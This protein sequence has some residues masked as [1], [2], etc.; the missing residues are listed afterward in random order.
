MKSKNKLKKGYFNS[1]YVGNWADMYFRNISDILLR[2]II[3]IKWITPNGITIFSS[4]IFI[5]GC[6]L[7]FIN[8]PYHLYYATFLIFVGYIGDLLDGDLAKKRNMK[9]FYGGYLDAIADVI[10]VYFITIS[11]SIFVYLT[12]NKVIFIFLGFTICASFLSRYYIKQ[13]VSKFVL[14]NQME[15]NPQFIYERF[16]IEKEWKQKIERKYKILS[17]SFVGR[18]KI[19]WLKNKKIFLVDEAEI[20]V[21][22]CIACI[23]NQLVIWI[24]ILAFSQLLIV[25]FRLFQRG[26]Q[27]KNEDYNLVQKT[28]LEI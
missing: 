1:V 21:F 2:L 4:F 15:K 22:T 27:L 18:L 28:Y 26:Y 20:A 25:V 9:S 14:I 7:L 17:K 11:L 10:K 12:T 19:L 8:I 13:I 5:A 3:K 16:V 24:W 6:F 23:F